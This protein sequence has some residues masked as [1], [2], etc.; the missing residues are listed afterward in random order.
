VTSSASAADDP[1]AVSC[2]EI[3]LAFID[4]DNRGELASVLAFVTDSQLTSAS[5]PRTATSSPRRASC[6]TSDVMGVLLDALDQIPPASDAREE[7]AVA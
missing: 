1:A 4:A 7:A 3:A 2:V 6:T 5:I